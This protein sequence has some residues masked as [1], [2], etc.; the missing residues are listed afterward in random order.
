MQPVNVLEPDFGGL[1]S[2]QR[3]HNLVLDKPAIHLRRGWAQSWKMLSLELGTQGS[4]RWGLALCFKFTD[5]IATAVDVAFQPLCFLTC[6]RDRPGREPADGEAPF[7]TVGLATVIEHKAH[8]AR[9]G[10]ARPKPGDTVVVRD[11]IVASTVCRWRRFQCSHQLVR[12]PCSHV[13]FPSVSAMCPHANA[14]VVSRH[15]KGCQWLSVE[16]PSF[17]RDKQRVVGN[18]CPRL[19]LRRAA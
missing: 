10:D 18:P 12:E 14:W 13:P 6:R 2:P 1:H 16:I 8:S 19:G 5:G 17:S 11:T 9:R 3:G 15:V 4:D 7:E